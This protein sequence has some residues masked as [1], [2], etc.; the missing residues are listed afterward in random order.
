MEDYEPLRGYLQDDGSLRWSYGAMKGRADDAW[1]AKTASM[2]VEAMLPE[3]RKRSFGAVWVDRF[4][5]D[6]G[7]VALEA[8]LRAELGPAMAVSQDGRFAAFDLR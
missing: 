5:Y 8:A 3:L 6:D 4:G 7:G 1:Q 2:T